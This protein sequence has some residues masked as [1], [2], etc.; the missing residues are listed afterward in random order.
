MTDFTGKYK[1]TSSD[2]FDEFLKEL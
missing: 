1:L 2:N